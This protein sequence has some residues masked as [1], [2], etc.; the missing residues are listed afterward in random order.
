MFTVGGSYARLSASKA[1]IFGRD[2]GSGRLL[3][4]L[5]AWLRVPVVNIS[6]NNTI[7]GSIESHF[8]M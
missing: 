8:V 4:C 1:L 3:F 7:F 2:S 6:T 5:A